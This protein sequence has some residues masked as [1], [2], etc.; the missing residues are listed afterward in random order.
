[1]KRISLGVVGISAL[2]AAAPLSRATAA[3]MAVKAPPPP[4]PVYSWT[5]FYFGG[6]A[7]WQGIA[8]A[9]M[10][11]APND[12]VTAGALGLGPCIAANSCPQNYGSA[13]GS[14]FIGGVQA[15]YNWQLQNYLVG[16]EAD[17]QGVTARASTTT[18]N[19]GVGGFLPFTGAES[20]RED[21]LGTVRGR[22]GVFVTPS[23]LGYATGGYAY[24]DV[25]RS[26]SASFIPPVAGTWAG[27]TTNVL[28]G[29]TAGG[30]VEWALS[31][32]FTLGVEYLYVRLDGDSFLTTVQ[33]GACAAGAVPVC[34]VR[35][36]GNFNDNIVRFKLNYKLGGPLAA[37]K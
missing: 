19:G 15:G 24:A 11:S 28:S 32:S 18:A 3:D 26:W 21:W 5:G 31:N 9:G 37:N 7:G 20:T 25:N 27:S 8:G 30:G 1:M 2:L 36:N 22:A 33:G 29:W 14:G 10:S 13:S 6:N 35:V 16:L 34:T 4:A 17:F 12:A 23:L